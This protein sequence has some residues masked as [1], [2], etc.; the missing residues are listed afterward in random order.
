MS[1]VRVGETGIDGLV[2]LERAVHLD[3]RGSFER[4]FEPGWPGGPAGGSV[5]QVNRSTTVGEGSVRGLHFQLPPHSESRL[6]TCARGR[7]YDVAVDLRAGSSSFLSWYGMELE[8]GDGRSLVIPPGFAHGFQVLDAEAILLYV[9]GGSYRPEAEGG[10]HPED[11]AVGVRWPL[12]VGGLSER[13][14]G[15]PPVAD[16]W[17]GLA[18]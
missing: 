18:S 5:G 9:H 10:I 1:E 13:D 15:H 7:V 3:A 17:T 14:Q 11:P 16:E 2:V 8:A 6:V 4:V 12:P